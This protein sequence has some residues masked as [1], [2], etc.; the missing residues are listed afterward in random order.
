MEGG[1]GGFG[2]NV[3]RPNALAIAFV[4]FALALASAHEIAIHVLATRVLKK[5]GHAD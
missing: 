3:P 4:C 5:H 2:R 1:F